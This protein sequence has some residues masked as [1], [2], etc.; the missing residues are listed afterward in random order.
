MGSLSSLCLILSI[1]FYVHNGKD[2]FEMFS[3]VAQ[4]ECTFLKWFS[5]SLHFQ[6]NFLSSRMI[7]W[8]CFLK[9]SLYDWKLE[10]DN[11]NSRLVKSLSFVCIS[12]YVHF[13]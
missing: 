9:A 12:I 10:V 13:S 7:T 4:S 8:Q 11:I 1:H 3:I 5:N 2:K 6:I